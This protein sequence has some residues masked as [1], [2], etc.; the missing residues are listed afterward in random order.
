MNKRK[1]VL[2]A[3]VCIVVAVSL[4][5]G[6]APKEIENDYV[7]I[8]G[9]TGLEVSEITKTEV[10]DETVDSQIEQIRQNYATYTEITDR[11]AQEGDMVTIDYSGAIDGVAFDGGTASGQQLELGA[12]GYIDGFEDGIVGHMAGETFDVNTT[13]PDPYENNPDLAGKDA[14]FTITLSKIE[15]VSLPELNDEFVTMVKGEETTV[16]DYKKKIRDILESQAEVQDQTQKQTAIMDALMEN[17]EL[18][19]Y[20][21]DKIEEYTN[22]MTDQYQQ[23]ATSLNMKYA[24]FLEQYMGMDEE[25]FNEEVDSQ[26]KEYVKQQ[27]V[28]DLIAEEEDITV[29][30]DEI[31]EWLEKNAQSQQ[32]TVDE[33]KEQYSDDELKEQ[34]LNEKVVS[35]L[36]DEAKVTSDSSDSE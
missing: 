18:K 22:L 27:E 24:D 17:V 2:A 15:E 30:D 14:V 7:K 23:I 28:L 12:G 20:P 11:A 36:W 1:K 26:V 8:N 31:N 29:S 4:L 16:D 33:L 9:Y 10:T 21:E 19:K 6:C 3:G 25:A 34:A 35:W 13:F 5:A 32:M